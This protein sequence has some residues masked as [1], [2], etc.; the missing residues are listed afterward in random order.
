[1]SH[2]AWCKDKQRQAHHSKEHAANVLEASSNYSPV[3]AAEAAGFGWNAPSWDARYHPTASEKLGS[4][5]HT[6]T[7]FGKAHT[8]KPGMP[9]SPVEIRKPK[10]KSGGSAVPRERKPS[11]LEEQP[12]FAV[13]LFLHSYSEQCAEVQT[14]PIESIAAQAKAAIEQNQPLNRLQIDYTSEEVQDLG[15]RAVSLCLRHLPTLESL[16]IVGTRMRHFGATFL[17]AAL[18]ALQHL[19]S[20]EVSNGC[21]KDEGCVALANAVAGCPSITRLNLSNCLIEAK[22]AA[23]LASLIR[24]H[25]GLRTLCLGTESNRNLLNDTIWCEEVKEEDAEEG[26]IMYSRYVDVI[27]QAFSSIRLVRTVSP[28]VQVAEFSNQI[29][30]TGA[31]E[32]IQ[33]LGENNTLTSL[34]LL[35]NPLGS[36]AVEAMFGALKGNQTLKELCFSCWIDQKPELHA[37]AI[38]AMMSTLQAPGCALRLVD[39]GTVVL[40]ADEADLTRSWSRATFAKSARKVKSPSKGAYMSKKPVLKSTHG[41]I[42]NDIGQFF[43]RSPGV[44]QSLLSEEI[45]AEVVK[46]AQ[47][48]MKQELAGLLQGE[49]TI[50]QGSQGRA[51]LQAQVARIESKL[52]EKRASLQAARGMRSVASQGRA[53]ALQGEIAKLEKDLLD[54]VD[55]YDW[56]EECWKAAEEERR[57]TGWGPPK[58]RHH[59]GLQESVVAFGKTT[60]VEAKDRLPFGGRTFLEGAQTPGRAGSFPGTRWSTLDGFR[61]LGILQYASVP[62]IRF[63]CRFFLRKDKNSS[64][65]NL[66]LCLEDHDMMLQVLPDGS[67]DCAGNLNAGSQFELVPQPTETRM[68]FLLRS[69]VDDNECYLGAIEHSATL[70]SE[71]LG[72]HVQ[73]PSNWVLLDCI[74]EL[75]LTLNQDGTKLVEYRDDD[76]QEEEEDEDEEE[77]EAEEEDEEQMDPLLVTALEL[78]SALKASSATAE[79]HAEGGAKKSSPSSEQQSMQLCAE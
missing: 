69:R 36:A 64:N 6:T 47:H 45:Q 31:E 4:P 37:E 32:L 43:F 74:E 5:L 25:K 77:E 56:R 65:P 49:R 18:P 60:R 75:P 2:Q 62:R 50:P 71:R 35:G 16:S 39:M 70:K 8:P 54:V 57:D 51:E 20:L 73:T 34:D 29:G 19:K 46:T 21:I 11:A 14:A 76:D 61:C 38:A 22:G 53:R 1:M 23:A 3:A 48:D 66:S 15:I 27:R 9:G 72:E 63:H 52:K 44:A 67:V 55:V 17:A 42:V 28:K 13:G 59:P 33:A 12:R 7:A 26:E 68:E 79:D 10:L 24:D 41:Q 40:L 30:G 78:R 58:G